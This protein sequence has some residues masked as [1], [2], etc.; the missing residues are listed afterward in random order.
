MG[1]TQYYV[2]ASLDGYIAED[3]GGL[4]WLY[5]AA[6]DPNVDEDID[7]QGFFEAVTAV[8]VGAST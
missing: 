6:G 3:D 8:A 4:Q 1:S 2:A 7:H 5:D